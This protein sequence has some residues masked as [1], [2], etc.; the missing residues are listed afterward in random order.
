[1]GSEK[2][3]LIWSC[4]N[5]WLQTR[6]ADDAA[7]R[8]EK[9]FPL[10]KR[11]VA[12]HM[13]LVQEGPDGRLHLPKTH[14]PEYG[15]A[16]DC[17]YDLAMLRWGCQT[18]ESICQEADIDDP[19]RPQWRKVLEDLVDFPADENGWLIGRGVPMTEGHRHYSHLMMF[20]PLHLV[21]WDQADKRDLIR[22]SVEHWLHFTTGKAGYTYT[23]AAA[24]Y[25]R[26]G[27]PDTAITYL[28][29]M[30][31]RYVKP[32]TM[33]L[34]A[35]PVIE[36][37]LSAAS[38]INDMLLQSW[39]D[40]V[41]VFPGIPS[42]WK[43]ASFHDLRAEG[44]FLVSSTLADGKPTFVQVRAETGGVCRL[45]SPFG[46]ATARFLPS[47]REEALTGPAGR[48]LD[49]KLAKGE[50]V[51]LAPAG[52]RGALTI[53][54]LSTYTAN[55]GYRYGNPPPVPDHQFGFAPALPGV[56]YVR[57]EIPGEK[58]TL[59]LGEVQVM[60]GDRNVA[61]G[62]KAS[63]STTAFGGVAERAVDGD[64]SGN[65]KENT[66]T[67]TIIDR[68]DPWWEVD[69]GQP[70]A[71]DAVRLFNRTDACP[72]RLKGFVLKLLDGDRTVLATRQAKG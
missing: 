45:V 27:E 15:D 64:C 40:R 37:P 31:N 17:N 35:G 20:Y 41:R 25:L 14:S 63:Q 55:A 26:M 6:Y 43:S 54:P 34:E 51:V 56:R 21:T 53:A 22:R 7:R 58:Q 9:L 18:L 24:M 3:N 70:A 5:Y 39:G 10:L 52:A 61:K 69:L 36:T 65:W 11:A 72:E 42:T 12:Y 44:A 62:A 33:Y 47:G 2:G 38:V 4:H 32:N 8:R 30:L 57:V 1:V 16:P 67:H 28:N 59:S 49:L 23:G 13:H 66:V 71:V 50:A 48:L 68:P 19:Q 29:T 46:S 60:V